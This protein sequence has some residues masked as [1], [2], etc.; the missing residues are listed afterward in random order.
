[1]KQPHLYSGS[2][3][4]GLETGKYSFYYGKD[5]IDSITEEFCF[6]AKVNG[7]EKMRL[8]NSQL[9]Y[10]GEMSGPKSYLLAG[11]ALYFNK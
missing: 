5:E 6:V 3:F 7:V 8:R 11:I 10:L 2:D 1:M 4:A 9:D